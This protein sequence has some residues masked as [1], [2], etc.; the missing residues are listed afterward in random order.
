MKKITKKILITATVFAAAMNMNGCGVYGPPSEDS[1]YG[2]IATE[3]EVQLKEQNNY[4]F[5]EGSEEVKD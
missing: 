4:Q 5:E 3:D 2:V 1:D